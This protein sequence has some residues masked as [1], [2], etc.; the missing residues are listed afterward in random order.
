MVDMVVRANV[1]G[2]IRLS[3][4]ELNF[5]GLIYASGTWNVWRQEGVG[6]KAVVLR[7]HIN[8]LVCCETLW[9]APC[10]PCG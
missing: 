2:I 1:V 8:M 9:G 4:V 6:R 10:L 3:I 7:V 5:R